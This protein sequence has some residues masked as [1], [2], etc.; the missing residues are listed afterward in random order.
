MKKILEGLKI[1]EK[2][3]KPLP[4]EKVFTHIDD[5]IAH[6]QDLNFMMDILILPKTKE[7]YHMLL[8][9]VDMW[10]HEFDI[11]PLKT[12]TPK[13][14]LK[15]FLTMI[16]RDHIKLP[17]YKLVVD[18]DT[19]FKAD[20]AEYFRKKSIYLKTAEPYR[21]KQMGLIESYN[22]QIG[23][24]IN[25][26]LNRIEE[27]TGKPDN[28]W[29]DILPYIR[30]EYNKLRKR[31]D[32]NPKTDVYEPPDISKK[33]EYNEGD[34]VYVKSEIPLNALG[35]PQSDLTRFRTGDYRWVRV[36][37]K[38]V[39]VLPMSGKVPYRYI[40]EGKPR[41]SYTKDE[42]MKAPENEKET[43]YTVEKIIGKKKV[44]NITFYLVKWKNY[45]KDE[46]TWEKE[47]QLIEDG[48]KDM[49]DDFNKK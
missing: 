11:E 18:N 4:K 1:N 24:F 38:I 47:S 7:G 15:A 32:G 23:R 9:C 21:H 22:K 20:F 33:P 35:K 31:K 6:K 29:L 3:T 44:K 40:V 43:K 36:P 48:L 30:K 46:S 13:E 19:A 10:S 49:I 25:G 17:Y 2:Y 27:E 45:K 28:E 37:K 8:V 42:I 41:V 14:V 26:Y 12:R 34:I 39:K 16:K 5:N